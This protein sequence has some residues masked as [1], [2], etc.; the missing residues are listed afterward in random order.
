MTRW[1][2]LIMTNKHI[3]NKMQPDKS[4]LERLKEH[5]VVKFGTNPRTPTDFSLL[6]NDI[7]SHTHRTIGVSTL[8]RIFG[9]VQSAYGTSFSTLS[10]LSSYLGY[11]DWEKF[12]SQIDKNDV[13]PPTSGF[14]SNSLLLSSALPLSSL[15]LLEW[16]G[17]KKCKLRKIKEPDLFRIEETENI[18]LCPLDTG[19]IESLSLNMPLIIIECQRGE[20]KLGTYTGATKGGINTIKMM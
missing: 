13:C 4:H 1:S 7:F 10:H 5:I 8:K 20:E 17:G 6:A 15:I 16:A 9:Y 19:R 18:K 11:T 14:N 2:L 3:T 12:C